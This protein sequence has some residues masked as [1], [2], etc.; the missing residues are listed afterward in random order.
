[1]RSKWAWSRRRILQTFATGAAV[2]VFA[3]CGETSEA[4]LPPALSEK[5][6]SPG[7]AGAEPTIVVTAAAAARPKEPVAVTLGVASGNVFTAQTESIVNGA[8]NELAEEEPDLEVKVVQ[9]NVGGDLSNFGDSFIEAVES[10]LGEG[11]HWTSWRYPD[12]GSAR[13]G[14]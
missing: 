14:G 10:A 7:A 4:D 1:M 11:K 8:V 12:R 13:S 6:R 3:A 5:L 9:V 2:A